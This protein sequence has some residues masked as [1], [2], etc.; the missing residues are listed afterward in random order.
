MVGF[1]CNPLVK[2]LG[3]PRNALDP[4]VYRAPERLTFSGLVHTRGGSR[5]P[6]PC[7]R[8]APKSL[9]VDSISVLFNHRSFRRPDPFYPGF[10]GGFPERFGSL[11]RMGRRPL[12]T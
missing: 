1:S 4:W 11:E 3:Q 8:V 6:T 2:L 12:D 5:P 10:L 9:G 7:S